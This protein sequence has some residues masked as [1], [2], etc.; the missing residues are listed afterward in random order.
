MVA[1]EPVIRKLLYR[2][3]ERYGSK[4][5]IMVGDDPYPEIVARWAKGCKSL[6]AE[7]IGKAL[8]KIGERYPK[9]PPDM[10]EFVK[11]VKE[12]K[13]TR[14]GHLSGVT[15]KQPQMDRCSDKSK[16][17]HLNNIRKMI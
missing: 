17:N 12:V 10:D 8:E 16:N 9:Q 7:S 14:P 13:S 5:V 2:L 6:T 11:F 15:W 3:R 1:T 4:Y